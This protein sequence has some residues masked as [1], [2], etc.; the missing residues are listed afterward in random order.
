M[1]LLKFSDL[2]FGPFHGS[3]IT[4]EPLA[5]TDDNA[6]TRRGDLLLD[7][8]DRIRRRRVSAEKVRGLS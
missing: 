4:G 7:W 1:H 6:A 8:C 2:H 5:R 3:E